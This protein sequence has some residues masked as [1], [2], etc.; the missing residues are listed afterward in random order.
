MNTVAIDHDGTDFEVEIGY[1][2]A[3]PQTWTDPGCDEYFE[4]VSI[5]VRG[6]CI[7][8]FLS[9]KDYAAIERAAIDALRSQWESDRYDDDR[10]NHYFDLAQDLCYGRRAA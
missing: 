8:R 9:Q 3:E 10:D 2:P 5:S 4:I 6:E 1:S 7:A